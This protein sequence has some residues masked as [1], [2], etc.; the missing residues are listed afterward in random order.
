VSIGQG[1]RQDAAPGVRES[2]PAHAD[3]EALVELPGGGRALFTTRRGGN[4]SMAAGPGAERGALL[5]ERLRTRLGV[6]ELAHVRQ[7]HGATVRSIDA[8]APPEARPQ[9]RRAAGTRA[10][11]AEADALVTALRGVALMVLVADCL[12]IAL[13]SDDAIAVVHAGWRG[14]AA[15]VVERSVAALRALSGPRARA[16]VA[17]VGPGAGA[18]CYEVGP[19]VR[20]ALGVAR[21]GADEGRSRVDLRAIAAARLWAA[22][23]GEVRDLGS[24]TICDERFYSHRREGARAGRQAVVAWRT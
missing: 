23:A 11:P 8:V 14:L 4:L 21:G 6:S 2:A 16:P 7:V 3:G 5:R 13:A 15:G 9:A 22:G 24:C 19:E 20:A 12:P 1:L 18:C 17:L 10:A